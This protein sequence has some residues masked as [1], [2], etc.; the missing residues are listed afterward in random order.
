MKVK[1]VLDKDGQKIGRITDAV[2]DKQSLEVR[3]LVLKSGIFKNEQSLI[4]QDAITA[5]TQDTVKVSKKKADLVKIES[6]IPPSDKEALFSSLM[7]LQVEDDSGKPLGLFADIHFRKNAPAAYQL[8]GKVFT[9]F[10]KDNHWS[11]NFNYLCE[12][13]DIAKLENSYQ[14]KSSLQSIAQNIRLNMTNLVRDLLA[15]ASKDGMVTPDEK[16][17]IDAVQIDLETYFAALQKAMEDGIITPDEEKR[18]EKIKEA[19]VRNAWLVA[20]KDNRISEDERA[21]VT[22]IAS[23]MVEKRR[24]LLWNVFGT[25]SKPK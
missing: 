3:G 16:A 7:R 25:I 4:S 9:T 24:E 17:I 6:K 14:L 5:I 1:E 21:L 20:Q 13:K 22:K 12:P 11:E 23:Y 10:L 2:V 8:G 18:L 15:T 19:I